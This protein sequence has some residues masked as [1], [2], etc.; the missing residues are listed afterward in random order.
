MAES[1][2]HSSVPESESQTPQIVSPGQEL[3]RRKKSY[4]KKDSTRIY[5]SN[6]FE[7]WRDLRERLEIENDKDLAGFLLDFYESRYHEET[8]RPR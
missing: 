5:L 1:S 8:N 2:S 7:R 6:A 4:A 3:E